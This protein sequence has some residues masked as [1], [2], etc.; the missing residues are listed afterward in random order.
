MYDMAKRPR[1]SG[2]LTVRVSAPLERR[3]NARAQRA[4]VTPSE[5]LRTALE[6]ALD[7]EAPAGTLGARGGKWLGAVED[8]KLRG[9]DAEKL[10]E[11]WVPG[12]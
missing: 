7:N 6:R 11:D 1:L 9:R 4:H 5:F 8:K 2:V 12:G 3:L 10:L